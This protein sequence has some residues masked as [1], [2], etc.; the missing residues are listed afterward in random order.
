MFIGPGP[1]RFEPRQG[2]HVYRTGTGRFE[3]RQESHVYR[4]RCNHY[5]VVTRS[6]CD[7]IT[8]NM[9][10]LRGCNT[11]FARSDYYKHA[12]TWLLA[13]CSRDPITINHYVVESQLLNQ[14]EKRRKHT[15]SFRSAPR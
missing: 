1:G 4:Y 11:L 12:T 3:L 5:V 7:P 15:E 6:S 2:F 13:H 9:Q 8:I 10:P 14:S